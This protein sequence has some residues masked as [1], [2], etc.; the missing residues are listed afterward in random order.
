MP[1]C[2]SVIAE[3]EKHCPRSKLWHSPTAVWRSTWR[4][5]IEQRVFGSL[6]EP[7]RAA[8]IDEVFLS[9]TWPEVPTDAEAIE[10]IAFF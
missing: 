9:A 1:M 3:G 4:R 8:F 5:S 10:C 6:V 2:C 7:D